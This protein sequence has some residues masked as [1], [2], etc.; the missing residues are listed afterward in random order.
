VKLSREAERSVLESIRRYP[1]DHVTWRREL[2]TRADGAL[3]VYRDGLAELL[4]RRLYRLTIDPD[5]GRKRLVR[6]CDKHGCANPHHYEVQGEE[7][8]THCPK[9]H[10][11][12][13]NTDPTG[14]CAI[15]A[16]A[17]RASRSGDGKPAPVL[18]A[19][20]THCPN[21]HEYTPR[22]TYVYVGRGG[23]HRKCR[24]CNAERAAARRRQPAAPASG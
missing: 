19:E 22:N 18:N 21:S 13:G 23:V 11:Y 4:H 1:E 17:R 8:R 2:Y 12:A 3:L 15:C 7:T 14:H 10:P 5:L 16:A 24:A 20:K 9:G 6:T